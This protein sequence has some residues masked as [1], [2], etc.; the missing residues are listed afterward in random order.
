V[1]VCGSWRGCRAQADKS[2]NG[3]T[4]AS[5]RPLRSLRAAAEPQTVGPQRIRD[6]LWRRKGRPEAG[7]E[8]RRA[9]GGGPGGRPGRRPAG[10]FPPAAGLPNRD[11]EAGRADE[12][13]AEG[14]VVSPAQAGGKRRPGRAGRAA[15]IPEA[16]GSGARGAP[17]RQRTGGSGIR[18]PGVGGGGGQGLCPTL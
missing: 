9:A 8:R 1:R 14:R 7:K 16:V 4:S 17:G 6:S 18:P 3:P 12:D 11:A 13:V 10:R 15:G 2:E 5:S